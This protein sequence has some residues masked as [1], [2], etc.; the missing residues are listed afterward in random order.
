MHMMTNS[1]YCGQG[2][3]S[4]AGREI[5]ATSPLPPVVGCLI[6]GCLPARACVEGCF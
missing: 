4:Y 3:Y 2:V 5:R 1:E 6:T